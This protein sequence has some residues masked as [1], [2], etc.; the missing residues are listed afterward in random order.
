[1]ECDI[2]PILATFKCF[3]RSDVLELEESELSINGCNVI[4]A[5]VSSIH[6]VNL[7]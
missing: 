3:S 7:G 6:Q 2:C 5:T 1:M 4:K